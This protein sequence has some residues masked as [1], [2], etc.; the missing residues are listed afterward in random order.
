[1]AG[2][3]QGIAYIA[4]GK[5]ARAEAT[6]SI[7]ALETQ[8]P[9]KV[10]ETG[11]YEDPVQASRWAKVNLDQLVPWT[12]ACYL[13][14]DT[15]VNADV[16]E[17]FAI[18]DDGWDWVMVPS[19]NQGADSLWHLSAEEREATI[20]EALAP[21]QL[22]AGV[23]WFR[24]NERTELLFTEWR[25]EWQRWEGQDQGAFLRALSKAPVRM[26]LLG[27]PWNGGAAIRHLF[28]RTR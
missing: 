12:D 3:S 4:I 6:E 22:Q 15:R 27:F 10:I 16:S 26:W 13:D 25:K 7:K 14:A 17:I 24:R 1:M 8:L 2:A 11:P 20:A 23:F 19:Q 21:L 28:G 18:L 5:E 9:V